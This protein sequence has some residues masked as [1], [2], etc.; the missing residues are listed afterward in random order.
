M[1]AAQI[2]R[3]LW[4][5]LDGQRKLDKANRRVQRE[6]QAAQSGSTKMV[7]SVWKREDG[8]AALAAVW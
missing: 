5:L 2:V 3:N 4:S 1:L 7:Q 6:V 8:V